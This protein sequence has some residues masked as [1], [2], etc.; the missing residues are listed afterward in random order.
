M[1]TFVLLHGSYQGGWIWQHVAKHLRTAGHEVYAPT[2]DGCAER[3]RQ[4][5]PGID[6]MSQ[7]Q[8]IAD[9]LFFEDLHDVVLVGTSSGGMVACR[10]A[11]LA[12]D[13]ITRL[14]FVDALALLDGERIR[15]I[16][17]RSTAVPS[18]LTSGPSRE[19]AEQ[20]LFADLES[21]TRAWTLDRYTQHPIGV[22]DTAMKLDSF[23]S[24]QW[25]TTVIWCRRAANPGEAHQRRTADRLKGKWLELDTGHYPMLS[26]PNEL[27]A[28]LLAE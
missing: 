19:D 28:M 24:Q 18:G 8:E 2:L 13:R 15:D 9:L 11:E 12:K 3:H 17:T 4:V 23:W 21:A 20:R 6:A 26:M 25:P 1:T 10:A 7:G 5:R 14:V 16:V 22:S 27:T